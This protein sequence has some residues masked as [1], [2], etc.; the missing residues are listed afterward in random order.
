MGTWCVWSR[1][2]AGVT[3]LAE[4]KYDGLCVSLNGDK[5]TWRSRT[6]LQNQKTRPRYKGEIN[7]TIYITLLPIKII[8]DS[9][10]VM[11]LGSNSRIGGVENT[12]CRDHTHQVPNRAVRCSLFSDIFVPTKS[13]NIFHP[14]KKMFV[15]QTFCLFYL[16]WQ[17]YS[18]TPHGG[19]LGFGCGVSPYLLRS[20]LL[21]GGLCRSLMKLSHGLLWSR[22]F[23][24][25]SSQ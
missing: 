20:K 23:L 8:F 6:R 22:E 12:K 13:R 11:G 14:Q 16:C 19:H 17:L 21:S 15:L 2:Q 5:S 3:K 25:S 9:H 10:I 24:Y 4:N 7:Q 18:I 1:P